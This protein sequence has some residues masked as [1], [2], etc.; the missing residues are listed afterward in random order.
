ML[1]RTPAPFPTESMLGYL[2]RL[3]AT[4]G[5]DSPQ[6]VLACARLDKRDVFLPGFPTTGLK[7]VIGDAHHEDIAAISYQD[8]SDSKSRRFKILD[9]PIGTSAFFSPFRLR[10]SVFCTYCVQENGF[11][12]AFW[13]LSLAVACPHHVRRGLSHCQNCGQALTVFR[14][15]LLTCECGANLADHSPAHINRRLRDFMGTVYAKLHSQPLTKL[16]NDSN[17]PLE[18]LDSVPLYDILWMAAQLGKHEGIATGTKWKQ[19]NEFV[20]N[21]AAEAL[22]DWPNGYHSFLQRIGASIQQNGIDTIGLRKQFGKF[23]TTLFKNRPSAKCYEFLRQEFVRFG[24]LGWGNAIVDGKLLQD[25]GQARDTPTR[26]VSASQFAKIKGVQPST[27]RR[28]AENGH[29]PCKIIHVGKQKRYVFDVEQ[30]NLQARTTGT[31]LGR[32]QAGAYIGLPVRV[33]CELKRTGHFVVNNRPRQQ[34]AGFHQ[35]DLDQF[36]EAVLRRCNQCQTNP[37]ATDDTITLG[38]IV[39]R[40]CFWS[41]EGKARFLADYLDGH[42][43]S[44]GIQGGDIDGIL[45]SKTVVDKHSEASREAASSGTLSQ[46][47]SEKLLRCAQGAVQQL[48]ELGHLVGVPGPDRMRVEK[49]SL[50]Q[51]GERFVAASGL[52]K[53]HGTSSR[54]LV[55]LAASAGVETLL[56]PRKNGPAIP[57]F[58]RSAVPTVLTL[59]LDNP[60]R[61][62]RSE[63]SKATNISV[64]SKLRN[65]F[66]SLKRDG[67]S[68]PRRTGKPNVRAIAKACGIDRNNLYANQEAAKMLSEFEADDRARNSVSEL[69][70]PAARLHVYLSNLRQSKALP[71][72]SGRRLSRP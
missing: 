4:N 20:A 10:Q 14:R 36:R 71:P 53:E 56:I 67:L 66:D 12:D 47:E 9:H 13:D 26:Y 29:V 63:I 41:E 40:K 11:I 8:T 54:R 6:H 64:V 51:F 32:R 50:E 24:M 52:A 38:H 17:L 45:F 19:D 30:T 2:L 72:V 25:P 58:P 1:I 23:Y 5:Y 60:S 31:V 15:N 57:F 7:E 48:L 62:R 68:L 44:V 43:E 46:K 59:S 28:W 49:Q 39:K 65:Y 37:L 33:L 16:R 35:A 21:S 55:T 42:I 61:Q 18:Q 3:S 70:K 69:R 34:K 22:C 27:L